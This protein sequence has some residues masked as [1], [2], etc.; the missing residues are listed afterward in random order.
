MNYPSHEARTIGYEIAAYYLKKHGNEEASNEAMG[1]LRV[2][3]IRVEGDKVEIHLCRPGL[4]IG[5]KGENIEGLIKHLN[6]KVH[7]VEA[8]DWGNVLRNY[9]FYDYEDTNDFMDLTW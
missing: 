7:I 4:L 2:T 5:S 8:F 6:K 1:A 3:D 9:P